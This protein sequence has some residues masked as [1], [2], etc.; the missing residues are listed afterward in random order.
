[1]TGNNMIYGSRARWIWFILLA[2]GLSFGQ[3]AKHYDGSWWISISKSEQLGFV[4]GYVD[5]NDT[6]LQGT[7]FLG[8][9]DALRQEV[10]DYYQRNPTGQG[11]AAGDILLRVGAASGKTPENAD[12]GVKTQAPHGTPEVSSQPGFFNGDYW[13]QADGE[14]RLGYIEGYLWCHR[15]RHSQR[16]ARF[17]KSA[18]KYREMVNDWYFSDSVGV[19]VNTPISDVLYRVRDQTSRPPKPHP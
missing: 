13:A 9:Y 2:V 15:H 8:S 7:N 18:I 16:R 19:R 4:S 10:S 6:E 11:M 12:Q 3:A 5:C 1:M 17:S 14:E